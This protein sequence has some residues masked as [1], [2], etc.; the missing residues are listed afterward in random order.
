MMWVYFWSMGLFV[1]APT[2][3]CVDCCGFTENLEVEWCPPPTVFF[4]TSVVLAVV[5]LLPPQEL[6]ISLPQS[7]S[8]S[9]VGIDAGGTVHCPPQGGSEDPAPLNLPWSTLAISRDV[10][11][12]GIRF[13]FEARQDCWI[14]L[15]QAHFPSVVSG[16]A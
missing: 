2:P 5:G 16:Q 6:G 8:C 7:L 4:S 10:L 1:T 11:S 9:V 14:S 12:K 13:C 3:H 15:T